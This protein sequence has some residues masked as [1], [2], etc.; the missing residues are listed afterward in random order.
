MKLTHIYQLFRLVSLLYAGWLMV[1]CSPDYTDM[2]DHRLTLARQNKGDIEIVA[3]QDSEKTGFI[4]GVLL[5]GE[6]INQRPDKLLERSLKIDIEP[7]GETFS[8]AKPTIRRIAANPKI[9]A[10]IGHRT[11]SIATPAS[12]IY[13]RSQIIFMPPVATAKGLTGRD[14]QYLFRMFPSNTVIAEQLASVAKTLGYKKIV[15]LYTRDDL[16]RELA[17]LFEEATVKQGIQL[18]HRSS[19]FEKDD[20]YRSIISQ[21]SNK[22]FDAVF[23]ASSGKPAGNMARQLREMGVNQPIIGRHSL[24]SSSYTKAAGQASDNTIA[25]TVLPVATKNMKARD[26]LKNYQ[27]RYGEPPDYEAAQ[28]YDSVMLLANA[29]QQAGSTVPSL[30]S[31]T[32]HYMP[33]WLGVTGLHAF[34]AAGELRGK[35]YFFE[36]WQEGKWQ[37]L[38]ALQVPYLIGRFEENLRKKYGAQRKLTNFTEVLTTNMHEDEHNIYLLDLAQEILQ[39]KRIGIIYENTADGRNASGYDLLKAL[40]SRKDL[41]ISG[42][43]IAFSALDQVAIERAITACYGKLSLNIDV[44]FVPPYHGIAPDLIQRLNRSLAFF[45]IPAISLNERNTDP[46]IS[47]VLRN[48]SDVNPQGTGGVQVYSSLLNGLKVHEFAEHMNSLPELSVN[49]ANLQRYGLPDQAI[50]D[51]SPD[52]YLYSNSILAQKTATTQADTKP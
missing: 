8:D 41:Q 11:S 18:V 47:L 3:I 30:L 5:A 38:P 27:T 49:L 39:F 42:C 44:M 7:D 21:F 1:G 12:L 19:F 43:E 50:L 31:S 17:F 26:F 48:R 4:K 20:D 9:T 15:M 29:I 25:P 24:H 16:S 14:F 13:E 32:L 36:V 51:L 45:K 52:N 40:A 37:T 10:V 33:A 2:A 28:G 35:M 6:E 34:D 22:D 46:S 23:I